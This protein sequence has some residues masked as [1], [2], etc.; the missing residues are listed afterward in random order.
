MALGLVEIAEGAE[1]TDERDTRRAGI[2]DDLRLLAMDWRRGIGLAHQ[3]EQ[4]EVRIVRIC[5]PPFAAVHHIMITVALDP[6]IDIGRVGR[7]DVRL[8]HAIGRTD[9]PL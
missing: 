5:D 2:Y 3:N 4:A 1:R 8:G 7:G 6:R 9:A